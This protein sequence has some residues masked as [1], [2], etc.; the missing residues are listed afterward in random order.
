MELTTI[1]RP[2]VSNG[3][4]IAVAALAIVVIVS[5]EGLALSDRPE[6]SP[7]ARVNKVNFSFALMI[8]VSSNPPRYKSKSTGISRANSVAAI[9][10]SSP[11]NRDFVL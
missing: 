8:R 4:M 1:W 3:L 6:R 10:P 9:P 2:V 5:T 11:P 7:R